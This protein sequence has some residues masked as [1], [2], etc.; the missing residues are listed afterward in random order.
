M[1]QFPR[2]A[3]RPLAFGSLGAAFAVAVL[4]SAGPALAQATNRDTEHVEPWRTP[5]APAGKPKTATSDTSATA[6]TPSEQREA[7]KLATAI[8]AAPSAG[9]RA[10]DKAAPPSAADVPPAQ[11]KPEWLTPD[12]VQ[13][14]GAGLQVKAPF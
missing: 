9:Q 12:G 2:F 6:P 14:G 10:A 1:T 11:P 5:E 4:A 3:F 13:P 7:R 8:F